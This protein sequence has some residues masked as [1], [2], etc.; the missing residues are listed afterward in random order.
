[1]NAARTTVLVP[2]SVFIGLLLSLLV[3]LASAC[4]VGEITGGEPTVEP[5]LPDGQASAIDPDSGT[6]TLVEP[7]STVDPDT[8]VVEPDA[9]TPD[10]QSPDAA[11]EPDATVEPDS[12]VEPDAAPEP[13]ATVEPD[14]GADP[15][16][17]VDPDA[18]TDSDAEPDSSTDPDAGTDTGTDTGTP[19]TTP[20][21]DTTPAPV[22]TI[23]CTNDNTGLHVTISGPISAALITQ[24]TNP[25]DIQFGGNIVGGV[26]GAQWSTC[27]SSSDPRPTVKYTD[28]V[29]PYSFNLPAG[30]DQI[31]F[32]LLEAGAGC[33]THWFDLN[34]GTAWQ[35][36]GD[37]Q[38]SGTL[39]TVK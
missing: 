26:S 32:Y 1:M 19:D 34:P 36:T 33:V 2:Q 10:S 3:A 35:V 12:A 27:Y 16:S 23:D 29:G 14:A 38:I 24:P 31:N 7:D 11:P 18:G 21:T 30:T 13:D 8:T 9:G 39:I 22:T 25:G 37:C 6:D 20:E 17:T 28:D 4:G 15:D 5:A